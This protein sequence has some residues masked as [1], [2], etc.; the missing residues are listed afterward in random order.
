MIFSPGAVAEI[1][2]ELDKTE[3]TGA[4]ELPKILYVVP[5]KQTAPDPRP[6]PM[7]SLVEELLVP[8]DMDEFRR[9]VRY[10]GMTNTPVSP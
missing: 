2:I 3:I 10:F 8:I 6:L 1:K 7:R 9:Q 5:W 4:R